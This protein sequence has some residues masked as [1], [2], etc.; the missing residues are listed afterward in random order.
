VAELDYDI[1]GRGVVQLI[2]CLIGENKTPTKARQIGWDPDLKRPVFG[3]GTNTITLATTKDASG[4]KF[5]RGG[6]SAKAG[7][8]PT[9]D[10]G[11]RHTGEEFTDYVKFF[12]TEPGT[13]TGIGGDVNLKIGAFLHL[14][15]DNHA[16]A[17]SWYGENNDE[18]DLL[19]YLIHGDTVK[20]SIPGDGTEVTIAPPAKIKEIVLYQLF[21]S[22]G[23]PFYPDITG[24]TASGTGIGI[25][26]KSK[27]AKTNVTAK[28]VGYGS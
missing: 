10:S 12:I 13:I 18:V 27:T 9:K 11:T 24:Y 20:D 14:I 7:A 4:S 16:L 19:P 22:N 21:Q 15:G 1:E 17:A 3:D 6:F 8:L 5:F 25:K 2:D 28:F 23:L 26:L